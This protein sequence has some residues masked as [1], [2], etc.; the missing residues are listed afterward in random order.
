MLL[1]GLL[2]PSL[3]FNTAVRNNCPWWRNSFTQC[4]F[5]I[6][7]RKKLRN[8]TVDNRI[9]NRGGRLI[10]MKRLLR[11]K[12]YIAWNWDSDPKDKRLSYPL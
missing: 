11:E 8:A 6:R 3:V 2:K 4:Y 5:E 7:V 9:K 10:L 12:P 1:G